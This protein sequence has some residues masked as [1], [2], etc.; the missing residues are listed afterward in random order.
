VRF[1]DHTSF[2]R[3]ALG[4]DTDDQLYALELS[5]TDD[6]HL[7]QAAVGAQADSSHPFTATGRWQFDLSPRTV[8][9]ASGLFRDASS[10]LGPRGG[11]AGLALGIA[12]S[13]RLALW[14]QG[15]VRFRDA[16]STAKRAYTLVGDAAFEVHRGVWLKLSPQ[17]H[18]EFGDPSAGIVR[19]VAGLNLLPRTHWN[20]VLNWYHDRDRKTDGS[21]RTLLAQLHLY[22]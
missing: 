1:A 13:S 19:F 7:V 15:D 3:S 17:L 5:Y 21:A 14:T 11:S 18:T 9:V 22:L 10:T 20:V 4:L 16:T 12:P 6:R 8:L 2:S